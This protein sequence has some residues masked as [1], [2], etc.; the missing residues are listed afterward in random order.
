MR[1]NPAFSMI[2]ESDE[3]TEAMLQQS[4][5]A[6]YDLHHNNKSRKQNQ[7]LTKHKVKT[8]LEFQAFIS[9]KIMNSSNSD[10][11]NS[12]HCMLSEITVFSKHVRKE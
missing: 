5:H 12:H 3:E 9:I 11:C 4:D 7:H 2:H 6:D 10:F 1:D 8:V